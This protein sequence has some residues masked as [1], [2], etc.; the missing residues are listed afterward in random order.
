MINNSDINIT[1]FL[2]LSNHMNIKLID[3]SRNLI[4]RLMGNILFK[5]VKSL[6]DK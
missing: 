6:K 1:I 4:N 3:L 2:S 5:S